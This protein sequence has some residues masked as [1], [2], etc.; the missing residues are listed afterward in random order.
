MIK[1]DIINPRNNARSQI[2]LPVSEA[3]MNAAKLDLA[4]SNFVRDLAKERLPA[5]FM[6]LGDLRTP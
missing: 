2:E 1:I 3:V 4:V 6:I 5:G